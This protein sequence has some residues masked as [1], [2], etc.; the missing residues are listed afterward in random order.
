[1]P[2]NRENGGMTPLDPPSRGE[3]VR[4]SGKGYYSGFVLGFYR[5]KGVGYFQYILA[6]AQA[7]SQDQFEESNHLAFEAQYPDIQF[8]RII[9]P[10]MM[11]VPLED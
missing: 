2:E 5:E 1:M 9:T 10:S 3:G 6:A 4:V 7:E 8:D 11:I